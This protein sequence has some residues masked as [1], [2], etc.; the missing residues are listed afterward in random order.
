MRRFHG[1]LLMGGAAI[2]EIDG[3]VEERVRNHHQP[4]H[5][6]FEMEAPQRSMMELGR[7]YLLLTDDGDSVELV[8]TDIG[9]TVNPSRVLVQ[10][11]STDN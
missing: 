2:R 8:V 1:D 4:R 6:S 5:G 3:E 7:P 10:F 11:E 9:A